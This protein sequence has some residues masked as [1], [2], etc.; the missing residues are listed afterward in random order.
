MSEIICQAPIPLARKR[1]MFLTLAEGEGDGF[2]GK[3]IA[4][5]QEALQPKQGEILC[6]TSH[7]YG[8][9]ER[10]E[11][12]FSSME[13][14]LDHIH[15]RF[16]PE[17]MEEEKLIWFC[18]DQWLPKKDGGLDWTATYYI[19]NEQVCYV[20]GHC[21]D[22]PLWRSGFNF[23]LVRSVDLPAPFCPGDL[24]TVDCRPFHPL[25]HIVI[26]ENRNNQD[27]Y[28][29]QALHWEDDGAWAVGTVRNNCIFPPRR[30][31]C[32][33]CISPLYHMATFHGQLAK[34]E[35]LLERASR[36]IRGDDTRGSALWEHIY[37]TAKAGH[38][39]SVTEADILAYIEKEDAKP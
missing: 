28:G 37:Q 26:L 34:E 8:Q 22:S 32:P 36:Y 11:R 4:Q 19:L 24:V 12:P 17:E 31:C 20:E 25:S 15:E 9:E 18:A 21:M 27:Y 16:D 14:L 3:Y 35:G 13:D 5:A 33:D 2:F 1:E 29:L 6:L 23:S 30:G 10:W 38:R 7:I 39:R